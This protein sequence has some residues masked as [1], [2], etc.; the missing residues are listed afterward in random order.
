[1]LNKRFYILS[2]CLFSVLFSF[3]QKDKDSTNIGLDKELILIEEDVI[4]RN[5]IDP[6]RPSKAAFYSA[7]LPGLGQIYNKRY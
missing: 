6:L 7:V 3:S 4:I 5:E 2:L 1:M